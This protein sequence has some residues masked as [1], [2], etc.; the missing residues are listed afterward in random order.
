[1]LLPPTNNGCRGSLEEGKIEK[2]IDD[3]QAEP[4]IPSH[5]LVISGPSTIQHSE[6]SYSP[7][8]QNDFNA[9]SDRAPLLNYS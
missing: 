7:S 9:A 1:M 4:E 3:K 8:S 6:E 2:V 5:F